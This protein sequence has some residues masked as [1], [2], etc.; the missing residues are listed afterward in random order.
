MKVDASGE[1]NFV[2][3]KIDVWEAILRVLTVQYLSPVS[4][5][6]KREQLKIIRDFLKREKYEEIGIISTVDKYQQFTWLLITRR[7]L[8]ETTS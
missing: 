8:N 2:K 6:H 3:L 1:E 7:I 5:E 4:K